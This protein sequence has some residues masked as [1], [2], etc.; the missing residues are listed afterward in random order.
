MTTTIPNVPVPTGATADEWDSGTWQNGV[1]LSHRVLLGESRS[2]DGRRHYDTVGVQPTCVQF[3]DGR[4]DDGSVYE[5]P[6]VYVSD[7]GY[8]ALQERELA[9]AIIEAANT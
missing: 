1:P 5:P 6:Q 7:H 9:A 3:S 4:I 2:V 8:P